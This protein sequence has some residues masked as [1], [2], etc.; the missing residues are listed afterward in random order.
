M[1]PG[2]GRNDEER[3]G[4]R[5]VLTIGDLHDGLTLD[6]IDDLIALMFLLRASIRAGSDRHHRRLAAV[7]LLQDAEEFA[8][9]GEHIHEIHQD[10]PRLVPRWTLRAE[11]TPHCCPTSRVSQS[12]ESRSRVS[13]SPER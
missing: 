10:P 12:T 1:M 4:T 9:V 2:A 6:H 13:Q 8:P 5:T 11:P 7:G 3:T